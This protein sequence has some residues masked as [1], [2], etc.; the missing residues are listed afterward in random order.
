MI[1]SAISRAKR[2]WNCLVRGLET[3]TTAPGK[4]GRRAGDLL[5]RDFTAQQALK[6]ETDVME[7]VFEWVHCYNG[8]RLQSTLEH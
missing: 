8:Q 5:N 6:T 2:A 1:P 7:V 4:D 3:R